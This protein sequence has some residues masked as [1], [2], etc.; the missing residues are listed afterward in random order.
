[1]QQQVLCF[2]PVTGRNGEGVWLLVRK[3][4]LVG[5]T[6]TAIAVFVNESC[7]RWKWLTLPVVRADYVLKLS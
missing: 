5:N 1:M 2:F 6:R 3:G 7:V 4:G